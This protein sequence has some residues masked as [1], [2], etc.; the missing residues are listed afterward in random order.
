MC[1][2]NKIFRLSTLCTALDR[3]RTLVRYKE[4]ERDAI[5]LHLQR[6]T[7]VLISSLKREEAFSSRK[8]RGSIF[9]RTAVSM[10]SFVDRETILKYIDNAFE[11][12]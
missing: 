10:E 6:L 12:L 11:M 1:L 5:P 3:W 2:Y 7:G 8:G 4:R 9:L